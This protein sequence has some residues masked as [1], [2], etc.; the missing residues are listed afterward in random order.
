MFGGRRRRRGSVA[1]GGEGGV[2]E[3]EGGKKGSLPYTLPS[4]PKLA[5]KKKA[6]FDVLL[7]SPTSLNT[8]FSSR[9]GKLPEEVKL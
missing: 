6:I 7:D 5:P 8:L 1:E 4:R 3:R 9:S 2:S